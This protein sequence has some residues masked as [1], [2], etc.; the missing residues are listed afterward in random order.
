[1]HKISKEKA[2]RMF[3]YRQN[4]YYE[5]KLQGKEG[6]IRILEDLGL[7]QI[8]TINI[9]SRSHNLVFHSRL[10]SYKESDLIELYQER[11]VFESYVHAMSLLPTNQFKYTSHRLFEFKQSLF[12]KLSKEEIDFILSVY[13]LILT[14]NPLTTKE[15]SEH[16]YTTKTDL[17]NWE[18]SPVRSALDS[19]WRSGMVQV[20]RDLKFNKLYIPSD[21]CEKNE[22]EVFNFEETYSY[23]CISALKS[24]GIASAKDIAD[25]YRI[26]LNIVNQTITRLIEKNVIKPINIEHVTELFYILE[27]D[28][29]F[30]FGN[31]LNDEPQ[32]MSFLSPFDNLIWYRIRLM[33]LFEVDYRLESYL[34]KNQ[35]KYGYYA[36]PIL[37]KGKI[38]GTIDLKLDKKLNVLFIEN[39]F[40]YNS[41]D[42]AYYKNE[43][44][45]LIK[46][47]MDIFNIKNLKI[48]NDF[49]EKV[50][51]GQT[52]NKLIEAI[53]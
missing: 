34:P 40:F 33:N 13:H 45:I 53:I 19:L 2:I 15:I 48:S 7:I 26:K 25:Y 18:M 43:F 47:Y 24:M 14:S 44:E 16:F 37:I 29:D 36:L 20:I 51:Y 46:K 50:N 52:L 8:D 38:I 30:I 41:F 28:Q 42:A 12:V 22:M 35:R 31:T 17:A 32:H 9:F 23:Y 21:T 5:P 11:Q 49:W 39:L 10:K 6:I 27:V 3:L 4:L 1:M